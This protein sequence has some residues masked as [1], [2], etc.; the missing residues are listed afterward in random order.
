MGAVVEARLGEGRVILHAFRV[1][2]RGQTQGTFKLLFNSLF[3]GPAVRGRP[4]IRSSLNA[5]AP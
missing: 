4:S 3:Y 5:G 2:H 1:Q